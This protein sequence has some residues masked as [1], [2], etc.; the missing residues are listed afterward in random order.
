[1]ATTLFCV[2]CGELIGS[3]HSFGRGKNYPLCKNPTCRETYL[4]LR[5]SADLPIANK[6]T[7]PDAF[8]KKKESERYDGFCGRCGKP[9]R[10]DLRN[11]YLRHNRASDC[12]TAPTTRKPPKTTQ[13]K[14]RRRVFLHQAE[15]KTPP[16]IYLKP[17]KDPESLFCSPNLKEIINKEPLSG[18][19]CK[20]KP[21]I[22]PLDNE[23]G[24]SSEGLG[25]QVDKEA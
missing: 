20:D 18:E 8:Y 1:M 7:D 6:Q 23:R 24:M 25:Q 19:E 2:I 9:L 21:S 10:I 17:W 12:K 16:R 13:L 3:S 15:P 4:N 22:T 11:S 5:A 14:T